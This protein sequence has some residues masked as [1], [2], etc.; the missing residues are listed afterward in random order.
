MDILEF[1]KDQLLQAVTR[2]KNKKA[3][4]PDRIAQ[5]I[6]KIISEDHVN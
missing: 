2:I 6:V 1:T 5:K 3:A 4:E